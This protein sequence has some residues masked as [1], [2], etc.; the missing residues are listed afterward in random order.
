[1]LRC[2]VDRVT[3]LVKLQ[4]SIN[5]LKEWGSVRENAV[6]KFT[7][8]KNSYNSLTEIGWGKLRFRLHVSRQ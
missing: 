7:M 1:M 5:W 6:I 4:G 3:C 8:H 2:P